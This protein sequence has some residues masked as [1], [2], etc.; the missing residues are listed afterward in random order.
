M[1]F[2]GTMRT[3][4]GSERAPDVLPIFAINL[5]RAEDRW[6][7][8]S[9]TAGKLRLERIAAVDGGAIARTDWIDIDHRRFQRNHGRRMLPGE[10]GCYRSHLA[11]LDAFIATGEPLGIIVE[12]D[13]ELD[14]ELPAR[15][16]SIA[17]GAPPFDV[18]KLV[19]H[20]A[21][22]FRRKGT[23]ALGDHYGRCV[24]GP[25]GSAACYAVTQEG[26]RRLRRSLAVMWL[27]Y[28]VALE[29][30]WDTGVSVLTTEKNLLA[31]SPLRAR[32]SITT[33]RDSSYDSSKDAAIARW[34]TALFRAGDYVRRAVYALA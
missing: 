27:P 28:D 29:R 12:D 24:H 19:N 18:I 4:D 32:S 2:E 23:S 15:V 7:A 6:Q 20:R 9:A 31:F 25:Q 10:Y 30:G 1:L 34:R 16:R 3:M 21:Y 13:I 11:A 14:E 5:D 22:G 17:A 26:A 33:G 8:L